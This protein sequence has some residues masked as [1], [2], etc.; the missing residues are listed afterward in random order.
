MLNVDPVVIEAGA[1]IDLTET[2]ET[3]EAACGCDEGCACEN[4]DT[5][6][7]QSYCAKD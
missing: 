5:C 3:L 4:H 7:C 2:E 1:Y 6:S